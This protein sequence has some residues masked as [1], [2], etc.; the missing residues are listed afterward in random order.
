MI[1]K[2]KLAALGFSLSLGVIKV[3][4]QENPV[5]ISTK[6]NTDKSVELSYEKPDPGTYTVL[7]KFRDL[8][9]TDGSNEQ[10]FTVKGYSGNMLTLKPRDAGQSIGYG[11]SY[12]YLRGKFEP[13]YDADFIYVLPYKVGS[14]VMVAESGFV[15]A[16]YFGNTAPDDWKVYRFYSKLQDTVTAVRKGVV[17]EIRDLHENDISNDVAYTNKSNDLVIEHADGTIATY[18]GFKKGSFAVVVGETVF[19]GTVLGVNSK[20]NANSGFNIGLML[21]Y[22]KSKDIDRS[23][24]L[25]NSKSLYGFI[26]PRF[27]T[28]ENA[29]VILEA[30][31]EYN[32]SLPAEVL[33]K[34][35]TKKEMKKQGVK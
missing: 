33:K 13:K 16:K 15:G 19:P 10:D 11:Y 24:T 32:A 30:K 3:N 29:N 12:T 5:K 4:A 28:A 34:E 8:T 27:A 17:V 9:N 2:I 25:Q 22:L 23:R 7:V 26:T 35:L 14:K 6:V 21:T 20:S 31:K 18:K 1:N